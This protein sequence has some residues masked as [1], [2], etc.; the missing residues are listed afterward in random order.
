MITAAAMM[1]GLRTD[2]RDGADTCPRLFERSNGRAPSSRGAGPHQLGKAV[3]RVFGKLGLGILK[4]VDP[5]AR[6]QFVKKRTL[7]LD[8]LQPDGNN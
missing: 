5:V 3:G 2:F 1:A 7:G 8:V 4:G 6:R